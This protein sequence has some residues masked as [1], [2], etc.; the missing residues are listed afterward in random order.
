MMTQQYM[1]VITPQHL[2]QRSNPAW[3]KDMALGM[4]T[5]I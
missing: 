4:A 5:I 2:R 3:M 1:V